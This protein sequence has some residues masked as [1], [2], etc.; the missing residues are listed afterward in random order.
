MRFPVLLQSLRLIRHLAPN[1]VQQVIDIGAERMTEVLL[2]AFGD[3]A[4]HVFE[5]DKAHYPALEQN[6]KA[7]GVY[8][9]L[10]KIALDDVGGRL[11]LH[12]TSADGSGRATH[13]HIKSQRDENLKGLVNI[14]TIDA[15]RLDDVFTRTA[16]GDL[17]YLIYLDAGAMNAKVVAGGADVIGGAS[18][19]VLE[20]SIGRQE[21]CSHVGL[22]AK[23]GFRLFDLCDNAYYF[24][25]LSMVGLVMIN[26]RLR[27]S[28]IRFRPWDYTAGKV[29]WP[30]WQRGFPTVTDEPAEDPYA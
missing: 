1:A 29:V 2:D 18:F 16:L 13:S 6:Y 11:H 24:G 22:L 21:L 10:H 15:M 4:H 5:P 20:A 28:E 30:R 19:V 12:H 23:H 25:Q 14:E 26:D 8:F 9:E 3:V 7:R 17:T 27:A